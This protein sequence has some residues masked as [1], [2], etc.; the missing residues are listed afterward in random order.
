MSIR[1]PRANAGAEEQH[2]PDA[3][4]SFRLLVESVKDYAIFMLDPT[5][6]ITSWNPGAERLKGYLASEIIGRHFSAFYTADERKAGKPERVL[7]RAL[8]EGR[9]EDEGWRVR[10]DGTLFW[11]DVIITA[12]YDRYGRH[13]G[14]AKVTRDLTERRQ[15]EQERLQLTHV[16]EAVRLREEFMSIAAHELRTPLN[17]LQLH[18]A[19]LELLLEPERYRESAPEQVLRKVKRSLRQA[20]RLGKLI[21]RLL[22]ISRI[23]SGRLSLEKQPMD[24]VAC[25]KEVTTTFEPS[26]EAQAQINFTGP[27]VADG[28]WDPLCIEQ[29]VS[30]LLENAITYGNHTPIDVSVEADAAAVVLNVSDQGPGI[31][32]ED[33]IRIFDRFTRGRPNGRGHGLGLGLYIA[34]TIVHAHGGKI[35][36]KDS[37]R[38]AHFQVRLPR[39]HASSPSDERHESA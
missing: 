20:N 9:I 30:N 5:G 3:E 34:R 11:A 7:R 15:A 35:E 38:G 1:E 25:V 24:L 22:D 31:A 23:A 16:E 17:A 8:E 6:T 33:R 29:V 27:A 26:V 4:D 2:P 21:S 39:N 13:R 32:A 37:E 12:V 10:K 14:F 18:L 28:C 19:G 36:L